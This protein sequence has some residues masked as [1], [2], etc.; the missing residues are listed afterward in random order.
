MP[1]LLHVLAVLVLGACGAAAQ[2]RDVVAGAV[3]PNLSLEDALA[4]AAKDNRHVQSTFLRIQKAQEETAEIRTFR[5]PQF[6]ID[7]K[8]GAALNSITSTIPAG[9]LGT[10][11]V[12]GRLPG[13]DAQIKNSGGFVSLI[14][15][16][17][18]QPLTQI[19]KRNLD[20][21]W[22]KVGENIAREDFRLEKQETALQVKDEYY[23]MADYQTQI[24]SAESELKYLLELSGLTDRRFAEETVLKSD[25]LNVRAKISQQRYQIM[26]LHDTL[27]THRES[28]NNLLARDLDIDFRVDAQ[29]LPS[30][31]ELD[32]KAARQKALE[33]RPEV[34]KARLEVSKT[35]LDIRREKSKYIPDLSAGV[36]YTGYENVALLPTS[37]VQA[38]FM[39][40][41]QPFD[42]GQKKD[43]IAQLTTT[44]KQTTL[45][46]T[47]V[48]KQVLL[49]VD[50]NYRKL[51]EARVLLDTRAAA[52]E[53]EREKLRVSMTRF[54]QKAVLLS[55]V[56]NQQAALVQADTEYAEALEG[57]WVARAAFERAL[58][59][60]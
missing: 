58:G 50:T 37:I 29:T 39:F 49:E 1:K 6:H 41:W 7:V 26:T 15:A 25:V 51:L 30:R 59:E 18:V 2:V 33:Q 27:Q 8:G 42:W 46:E 11:P 10:Y 44:N 48:E 47:D 31:E 34:R 54:E 16:Y 23:A 40:E 60:E 53:A 35:A 56:L 9:A 36:I 21:A 19:Y 4:I 32:L 24:E 12:I 20:I 43:R 5:Y 3:T 45:T 14:N 28:L 22:S 57:L 13:Q 55:D 38:G 17:A 52:Q